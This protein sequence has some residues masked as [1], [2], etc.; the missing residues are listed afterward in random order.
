MASFSLQRTKKI[1]QQK[2]RTITKRSMKDFTK[3]RWVDSLR[4]RDWLK[5]DA[6]TDLHNKAIV[7]ANEINSA[8]DECAPYKS[9]KVRDNYRPGL[10][11]AAKDIIRERDTTRR[12][13]TSAKARQA[14]TES[15]IQAT[16]KQSTQPNQERLPNNER[17]P[18]SQGQERG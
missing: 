12:N 10:S 14:S 5:I 17:R 18:H 9:F 16:E 8:L 2:P 13:I 6:T 15:K 11:E 4:N 7:F 1:T 3:T